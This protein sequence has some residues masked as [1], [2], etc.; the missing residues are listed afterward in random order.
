MKVFVAGSK[1]QLGWELQR[2]APAGVE[3]HGWDLPD[4]DITDA[5]QVALLMAQIKPD[6]LINSAAY[7]AV[8]KAEAEV[9]VAW[10]VNS[11]GAGVLAA[12]AASV[13]AAFLH[14]ST[15][16]VFDGS[17]SRPYQPDAVCAPVSVYGAS[18]LG[19]ELAVMRAHC[20]ATIIRTSWVYSV[21]G[22]NFVKTML[23]LMSEKPALNVIADQ[24]GTPTWARGLAGLLWQLGQSQ[25]GLQGRPYA[26]RTLHYA[27]AGTAS[28]FDYAVAIQEEALALGMLT[29]AIPINPIRTED[30]PTAAQRPSYSVM[31]R[32]SGWSVS[33]VAPHWRSQLRLMLRELTEKNT[34]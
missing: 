23:K 12:A 13:G 4:L 27:D 21:H 6:L 14:V 7:T 3:F 29:K 19:G 25:G 28:W 1:G 24:I 8:D 15:D 33:G 20:N 22:G 17:S 34:Q 11:D 10:R 26:G 5:P 31:N 30:Y 32:D 9:D 16:F 18:K 2:T